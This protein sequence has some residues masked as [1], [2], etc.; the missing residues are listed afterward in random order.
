MSRVFEVGPI[1]PP[2]EAMS[3]LIRVTRNCSWNKCG[4]CSLYRGEKFQTRTVEE[5]KKDIDIMYEYKN[6]ILEN[7]EGNVIDGKKL[8][9]TKM[10]EQF[11][12]LD[13]EEKQYYYTVLNWFKGGQKSAFLQ[14][15][16]TIVLKA[17]R[18]VEVVRYL[19]EKFPEIERI[20]SYARADTLSKISVE[21]LTMLREAG[22]N[23]IHS[24]YESGSDNVL[25]LIN[26]GT[27]KEQQIIGGQN[28][29]N[30]GM[31]LSVYFMPGVGG[32][33]F[34]EENAI[35]TADVINQVEPNFVR[36]RTFAVKN[37]TEIWYNIRDGKTTECSDL[38][39]LKEI[40]ILLE[41]LDENLTT[42]IK[43]DHIINLLENIDGVISTDK[44]KLI[45][46]IEQFEKLSEKEKKY[47]QLARRMGIIRSLDDVD[48][49][50]EESKQRVQGILDSLQDP[51]EFEK[52][53]SEL[54]GRYI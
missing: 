46:I 11:L 29:K 20:T 8:S 49:I 12:T 6:M 51:E 44:D 48:K 25:K 35:E 16:N 39:K 32:Q 50:P 18:L 41:N 36:I 1:R 9:G 14:D 52:T 3:L 13:D 37:E 30:A 5:I 10:R 26:K 4:F 54:I 53:L 34:T 21:D 47:Y 33:E 17:E 42:E 2:S 15:A 28:V 38:Q 31:E 24:G 45:G 40:K 27:T 19:K 7:L 43:S 23:R 22:L